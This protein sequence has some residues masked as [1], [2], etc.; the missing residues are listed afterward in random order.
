MPRASS[1]PMTSGTTRANSSPPQPRDGRS[2]AARA[3]EAFGD[4]AQQPITGV[5]AKGVVDFLETVEVE[6]GDRCPAR[7]SQRARRAI[8]EQGPVG[9]PG[10]Q[11]MSRLVPLAL[12]LEPKLLDELRP[13]HGRACVRGQR[14][15]EPQ[16]IVVERVEALVA[17]ERDKCS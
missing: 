1:G 4:V 7:V 11:V 17:V 10:Q 2:S 3:D 14:L 6:Q 5:V 12:G 8:E 16:V 13:L 15:E 9:E